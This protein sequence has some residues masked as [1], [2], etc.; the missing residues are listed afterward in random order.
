MSRSDFDVVTGPSMPQLRRPVLQ[1]QQT[2]RSAEPAAEP[3]EAA[4]APLQQTENRV[5]HRR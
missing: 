4:T 3:A 5:T 2:N 1:P